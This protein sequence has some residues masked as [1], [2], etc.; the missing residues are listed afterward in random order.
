MKTLLLRKLI[1]ITAI[2]FVIPLAAV[3]AQGVGNHL[4]MY[5]DNCVQTSS[6]T[7]EFDMWIVS[8]GVSSSDL[9]DGATQFGINFNTGI[10]PSGETITPSYIAGSADSIMSQL[11][12]CFPA[13]S[14]PDHLRFMQDD[15]G[16]NSGKT[17]VVGHSYRIGTFVLTC[18]SIWVNNSSPNLTLQASIAVGKTV[19]EALVNISTAASP[20]SIY[21]TG[22]TD[23]TRSLNVS[24]STVLTSVGEFANNPSIR[25]YPN[26]SNGIINIS[27]DKSINNGALSIYNVLGTD[28]YSET[29]SGEQKT[30]NCKLPA[31]VYL[32]LIRNDKNQFVRNIIVQ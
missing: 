5:L 17:M 7:L 6:N 29:F 32:V 20:T 9:R 11:A 21:V 26:P 15:S 24:C 4:T 1:G 3:F 8:D 12:W 14:S 25:I 28:V 13:S 22:T 23:S 16:N 27:I 31:G 19:C 10:L 2:L 18:S 30:V